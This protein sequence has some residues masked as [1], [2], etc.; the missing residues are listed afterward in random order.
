MGRIKIIL[1]LIL[2]LVEGSDFR[3]IYDYTGMATGRQPL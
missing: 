3:D 2:I 1:I